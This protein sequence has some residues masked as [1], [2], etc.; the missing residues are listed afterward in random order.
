MFQPGQP[1]GFLYIYTYTPFADMP[2]TVCLEKKATEL[3]EL[4]KL[5]GYSAWLGLIQSSKNMNRMK[6]RGA[7]CI[8]ASLPRCLS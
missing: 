2:L 7:A 8:H 6:T 5:Y 4:G 3:L 1:T